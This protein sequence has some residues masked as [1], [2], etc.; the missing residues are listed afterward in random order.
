MADTARVTKPA[1][2]P[3]PAF[4]SRRRP[5]ASVACGSEPIVS[6]A[7]ASTTSFSAFVT[8]MEANPA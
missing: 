7:R 2:E 5:I 8:S 6:P 4:A 3:P 1:G